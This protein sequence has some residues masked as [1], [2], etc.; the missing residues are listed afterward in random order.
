MGINADKMMEVVDKISYVDNTS[1]TSFKEMG[2]AMKQTSASSKAVGVDFD[3]LLSYLGT[4]SSVSRRSA[5]TIGASMRSIFARYESVRMGK[6]FD[7]DNNPLNNVEKSLNRIGIKMR[8]DKNTFKDFNIVLEDISKRWKNLNDIDKA[9]VTTALGGTQQ[10]ESLEILLQNFDKVQQ[11]QKGMAE[12]VGSAKSKFDEFYSTSTEARVNRVKNSVEDLYRSFTNSG[13][14]NYGISIFQDFLNVIKTF[15]GYSVTTKV[16]MMAL[17]GTLIFATTNFKTFTVVIEGVMK[18]LKFLPGLFIAPIASLGEL[19]TAFSTA[20][21]PIMAFLA[22]PQGLAFIAL[23]SAVGIATVAITQHS[24]EQEELAKKSKETE[25]T[26]QDLTKAME[27]YNKQGIKSNIDKL[28]GDLDKLEQLKKR[29]E[30]LIKMDNDASWLDFSGMANRYGEMHKITNEIDML[31]KS[32]EENKSAYDKLKQGEQE[33]NAIDTADKVRDEAKAE[34]EHRDSI[35]SLYSE[36]QTLISAENVTENNKKRLSQVTQELS[37]KV[38]GLTVTTDENGRMVIT[39]SSLVDKQIQ[40]YDTEGLTIDG[41]TS[42]MLDNAKNHYELEKGKTETSYQEITKRMEMAKAEYQT[43]SNMASEQKSTVDNLKGMGLNTLGLDPLSNFL[44]DATDTKK[45]E[46]DKLTSQKDMIDKIFSSSGAKTPNIS[47]GGGGSRKSSDSD[48]YMPSGGDDSKKKKSKK[49]G[50]KDSEDLQLKLDLT[51]EEETLL[52]K[53]NKEKEKT[54]QLEEQ[55]SDEKKLELKEYYNKL[56][57]NESD[58]TDKIYNKKKTQFEASKSL[59]VQ[60]GFN[61]KDDGSID[62]AIDKLKEYESYA[63]SLTGEERKKYQDRAKDL[64]NEVNLF[65]ELSKSLDENRVKWQVL[66][67]EVDKNNL[68]MAKLRIDGITKSFEKFSTHAKE[69][70]ADLDLVNSKLK[71][72]DVDGQLD[73]LNKRRDIVSSEIDEKLKELEKLKNTPVVGKKAQDELNEAFRKE[74][75][76]LRSLQIEYEN[77]NKS[78]EEAYKKKMQLVETVESKITD[79]LKKQYENRRKEME[80]DVKAQ[81]KALEEKYKAEDDY[82]KKIKKLYNEAN[83][84]A[85]RDK[86]LGAEN[87][88]LSELKDTYQKSLR[89]LSAYGQAKSEELRKQI[90]EQEKKVGDVV[91]KQER[92]R[93][94]KYL[95]DK[96]EQSGKGKDTALKQLDEDTDKRF[97]E[98]D[99]QWT[100]AKIAEK[101]KEAMQTGFFTDVYGEI[102]QVETGYMEFLDKFE[103]GTSIAG[104]GIKKEFLDNFKEMKDNIADVTFDNETMNKKML[105]DYNST[106]ESIKTNLNNNLQA[107]NEI[108][109]TGVAVADQ[110]TGGMASGFLNVAN[111]ITG[112]LIP[113]MEKIRQMNG[114]DMKLSPELASR[115]SSGNIGSSIVSRSIPSTPNISNISNNN[116][117]MKTEVN[118][119]FGDVKTDGSGTGVMDAIRQNLPVIANMIDG[120]TKR[121]VYSS[122]GY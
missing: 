109:A 23:A 74:Q 40:L 66:A 75:D 99:N 1:S 122:S 71:E 105:E 33:Y 86:E 91:E 76:A 85:D 100:P 45:A 73:V 97:L 98:F 47:S 12:S 30:D 55:A 52:A 5:D 118:L 56:L 13:A 93:Y 39:N 117:N 10:K 36:Y 20:I 121:G 116:R 103:N 111:V 2:D 80:D 89:D 43:L 69:L 31:T 65:Y 15:S 38:G 110:F 83:A 67:N 48:G 51:K 44:N 18:A 8:D 108:I 29:K 112:N 63:N 113:A 28:Q 26:V 19:S 62:N 81:K 88:K 3:N 25:A 59:L 22:T 94:N 34:F 72:N 119:R 114:G 32:I 120:V 92:D 41:L 102:K 106:G 16:E 17:V 27:T 24:K 95:D 82:W 79:M 21:T 42:V 14:I 87:K 54:V 58:V 104:Q 50:G 60:F 57:E 107:T 61:A 101:A 37:G 64:Q 90:E 49:S 9:T 11:T 78:I 4:I 46:L 35:K 96:I 68:D 77:L 115:V 70:L 53:I 7:P 6:S 84:D